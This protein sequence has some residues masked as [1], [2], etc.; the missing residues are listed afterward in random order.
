MSLRQGS[1]VEDGVKEVEEDEDG[2]KDGHDDGDED[3]LGVNCDGDE[4]A[5]GNGD[6]DGVAERREI[7]S[8]SP[9]S[10]G[11]ST[12]SSPGQHEKEEAKSI[13][14]IGKEATRPFAFCPTRSSAGPI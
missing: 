12:T 14:S 3:R 1:T 7:P 13:P 11:K 4:L 2:D 10:S 5:E 9:L 8:S 6:Q